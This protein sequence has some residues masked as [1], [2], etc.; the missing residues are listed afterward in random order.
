MLVASFIL[1]LSV[2]FEALVTVVVMMLPFG[3]TTL[4]AALLTQASPYWINPSYQHTS[5]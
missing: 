4:A 5:A 2:S 3:F 1:L